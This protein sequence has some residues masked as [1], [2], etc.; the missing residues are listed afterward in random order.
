M[1]CVT[2]LKFL[3]LA[4]VVIV[5]PG[6]GVAPCSAQEPINEAAAGPETETGQVEVPEPTIQSESG[7]ITLPEPDTSGGIPLM[8]ALKK[9][10]TSRA[11]SSREIPLQVLGNLLWAA[12][13]VN[14]PDEGKLTAPTAVNWQE[15]DIYVVLE[16][17]FYLYRPKDHALELVL[18]KDIRAATG[19]QAFV[20]GA[21]VNLVFVA[22]FSRMGRAN[23]QDRVFYSAT[24]TGFR[25]QNVYLFCAS[26]G[27]ATVVRGWIDKP[28]LAKT[29]G[30]RDD[31]KIILAQTVG[32]QKD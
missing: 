7:I 28:A 1:F 4:F 31:Q 3:V 8:E 27:L 18:E 13:G 2:R 23:K 30:L 19:L 32:Y 14:R 12:S 29:M 24:D 10:K 17:G 22:D 15:I 26:A 9:R 5:L 16:K 11:F 6:V 21:P 20:A 25:S